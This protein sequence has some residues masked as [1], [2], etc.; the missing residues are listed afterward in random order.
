[1]ILTTT[2]LPDISN[3]GEYIFPVQLNNETSVIII[4][5]QLFRS[6]DVIA[7]F[8]LNEISEDSKIVAGKVLVAEST[9]YI[10]NDY[11]DF[12][13]YIYISDINGVNLPITKNN[14]NQF[15]IQFTNYTEGE[16]WI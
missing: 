15:Y 12:N 6:D 11:V 16:N 3:Y 10:P 8:Y 2:K 7:D 9:I 1:M 13:Y 5:K 4:F 14:V